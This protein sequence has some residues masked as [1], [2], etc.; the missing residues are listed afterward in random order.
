MSLTTFS[1]LF[2]LFEKF[3]S[4]FQ[5]YTVCS[6]FWN[7]SYCRLSLLALF[8]N[9]LR[10]YNISCIC[11]TILFSRYFT[12]LFTSVLSFLQC[13]FCFT[14]LQMVSLI[15]QFPFSSHWIY[16]YLE[17]F[18]FNITVVFL[19]SEFSEKTSVWG[20]MFIFDWLKYF[21]S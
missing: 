21:R 20:L 8:S 17:P 19:K 14:Q 1:F 13:H 18:L 2:W 11:T 10:F 9:Y 16:F 3:F 12:N 15:L 5:L 4:C 7:S 6:V